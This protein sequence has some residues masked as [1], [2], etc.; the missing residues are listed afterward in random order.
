MKTSSKE[1]GMF[2][3]SNGMKRVYLVRHGESESNVTGVASGPETPLT[4]EGERQA[5]AIADRV[6]RID[7]DVI[8]AS[9]YLRT[10][11]TARIINEIARKPLEYSELFVEKRSPTEHWGK[12]VYNQG[13]TASSNHFTDPDWKHSDEDN[14]TEIKTRAIAALEYLLARP[15]ENILVVSH[16]WFLRVLIAVQLFGE[17]L[18]IQEYQLMWRFLS[19][20]NTGLTL[21]EYDPNNLSQGWRLI[22]WNDHAHLG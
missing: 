14:F 8:I 13:E 10:K 16:G 21:V 1:R 22:T 11:E 6:T 17:H 5:A 12:M 18:T 9:P 2:P 3:I 20:R 19:T 15:E 4:P 7:V